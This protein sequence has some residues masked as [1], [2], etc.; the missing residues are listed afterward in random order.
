MDLLGVSLLAASEAELSESL[1]N[2][3]PE[4][5]RNKPTTSRGPRAT[6][7]RKR[8]SDEVLASTSRNHR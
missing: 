2:S 5:L 6:T 4:V 1:K 8:R 7:L 3:L